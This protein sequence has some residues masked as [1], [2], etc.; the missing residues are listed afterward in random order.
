[1]LKGRRVCSRTRRNTVSPAVYVAFAMSPSHPAELGDRIFN[2][3]NGTTFEINGW[4]CA[5]FKSILEQQ[6]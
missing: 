6:E 3:P 5:F 2:F 1:M 4:G